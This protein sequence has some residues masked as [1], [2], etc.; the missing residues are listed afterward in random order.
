M[1]RK[2]PA[3][4][5]R[6]LSGGMPRKETQKEAEKNEHPDPEGNLVRTSQKNPKGR[7]ATKK[8]K[9]VRGAKKKKV[10]NRQIHKKQ[11]RPDTKHTK[12]I[13]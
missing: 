2:K 5:A 8:M 4:D 13:R 3:L 6:A 12:Q 10:S 11:L 7:Q 9:T 1:G